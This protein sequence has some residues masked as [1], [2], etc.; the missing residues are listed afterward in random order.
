MKTA[1]SKSWTDINVDFKR[2]QVGHC[3]KSVYYDFPE[4]YTPD[5]FDNST[6]IQE[7]R[8]DTMAGIQHP[9]CIECW[10]DVNK[11]NDTFIDWWN[12]W[13]DFTHRKPDVSHVDY[14][15]IEL[16][17]T[18]DLSCLYCSEE[19][20]SKIAQEEGFT[21]PDKTRQ[22][23]IDMFKDWLKHKVNSYTDTSKRL[24][25]SF[26]GGEPTAS[27]LFYELLDFIGTLNTH[28]LLIDVITNG[29]SRPHLFK[30]FLQAIDKMDCKW[31]ITVSN[32]S[33][34][35]DS[36]LIRYGLDWERFEKNVLAYAQHKK[37]SHINFGV[38]INNL[39]L[40]SFPE[41]VKWVYNIM[42]N[43][44]ATFCFCGGVVSEPTEMDVA[45]YPVSYKSYIDDTVEIVNSN[46]LARC[47]KVGEFL[48][49]LKSAKDR[50]G[51]DYQDDYQSIIGKHL[52]YKQRV[53][54]T[55]KLMRLINP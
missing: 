28:V 11:G 8:R 55:D 9:D 53:K 47:G 49:F 48:K 17:N 34:G 52:E 4:E 12:Q 18:C 26:S 16:D 45:I 50:I 35:E 31:A 14:I 20:S 7:R 29:N 36:Q 2:G 54:K 3:C 44:P 33:F 32:E 37:V 41:Y 19:A 46:K 21:V 6:N 40:P 23:D 25:I 24:N 39:C 43:Q 13:D 15:E 1:C 27:K 22:Y 30:K 51:S 5:F 42:Q 38:S 10:K